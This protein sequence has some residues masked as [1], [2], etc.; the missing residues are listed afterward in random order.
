MVSFFASTITIIGAVNTKR[1]EKTLIVK[2]S[3]N[4]FP[5]A[6]S[7]FLMSYFDS[8]YL[9]IIKKLIKLIKLISFI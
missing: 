9:E 4:P 7:S 2:K 6:L 3:Q 8:E 5:I 1:F